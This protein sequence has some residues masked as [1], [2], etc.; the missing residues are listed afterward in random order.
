MW[1]RLEER[2][3]ITREAFARSLPGR[4]SHD[5]LSESGQAAKSGFSRSTGYRIEWD[6]E[7]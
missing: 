7:R 2:C 4:A 6:E 1:R 3:V 5:N